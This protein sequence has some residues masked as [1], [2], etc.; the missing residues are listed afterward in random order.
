VLKLKTA[1]IVEALALA[2]GALVLGL[3]FWSYETDPMWAIISFVLVYAPESQ[4]VLMT[5]FSRLL[6]T[7][8]GSLLAMGTVWAFGVHKWTLP[9]S[10]G[11]IAMVCGLFRRDRAEQRVVLVT[12]ALIIGSSLL[13]AGSGPYIALTRSIEV[14]VGSLLAVLFSWVI[15]RL[16]KRKSEAV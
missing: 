10:V 3:I 13:E 2:V 5:A 4:K 12:V 8:L 7:I 6:M 9:V 15:S 14:T 11:V 1:H 16:L